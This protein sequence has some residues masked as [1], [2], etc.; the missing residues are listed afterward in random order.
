MNKKLFEASFDEISKQEWLDKILKDLKGKSFDSLLWNM[1]DK[2]QFQ[3]FYNN[4]R[5]QQYDALFHTEIVDQLNDTS[6]KI[7]QDLKATSMD[8]VNKA[9]QS[10]VDIIYRDEK[11]TLINDTHI[12]C[13][14]SN[15][16]SLDSIKSKYP[17]IE[18]IINPIKQWID[19]DKID[20]ALLK[21]KGISIGIDSTVF[22][23][24]GAEDVYELTLLIS[25]LNEYFHY[26]KSQ[27]A[28]PN[29]LV[30]ELA[31]GINFYSS[32]AKFRSLRIVLKKLLDAYQFNEFEIQIIASTSSYYNSHKDQYSNLLRHTTMGLS[33]VLGGCDALKIYPFDGGSSLSHRMARNIQHLLKEEAYI[34]KVQD[35]MAGSYFIEELT[36]SF[37]KNAWDEFREIEGNGGF[38]TTLKSSDIKKKINQQHLS[39]VKKY[40]NNEST[41][42]GVNKFIASDDNIE[43]IASPNES[44]NAWNLPKLTLSTS[45]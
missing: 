45:I 27:N 38:I 25:S 1:D 2:S 33:A 10:D 34:D 19:G 3:P 44:G 16:E 26:L 42:I 4:E 41:M 13:D 35:M 20:L 22:H 21:E 5:D 18:L 15:K 12:Y 28:S 39:R 8:E 14:I 9:L 11:D 29:K 6:W 30:I 32:I 36:L 43:T 7:I 17:V 40:K 24:A 31:V 23:N 37:I